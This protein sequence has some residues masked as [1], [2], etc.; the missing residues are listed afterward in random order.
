[1]ERNAQITPLP[2]EECP[3]FGNWGN[4]QSFPIL[5]ERALLCLEISENITQPPIK[6]IYPPIQPSIDDKKGSHRICGQL[7]P[8]SH[9]FLRAG[10]QVDT[11]TGRLFLLR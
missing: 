9:H 4:V 11:K 2:H 7:P 1:M 10:R 5:K 8:R 6:Y 3:H